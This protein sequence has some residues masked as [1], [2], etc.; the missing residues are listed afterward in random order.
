M[1]ALLVAV[2][3]YSSGNVENFDSPLTL[4]YLFL[5]IAPILLISLPMTMIIITG[6]IDL[7][8]ASVVGL[9]QRA[10]G[11]APPGRRIV[12]PGRRRCSRS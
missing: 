4:Y 2:L 5:D 9:Q 7:S 3:F 6:E 1:I 10:G 12:H 11:A 8:V